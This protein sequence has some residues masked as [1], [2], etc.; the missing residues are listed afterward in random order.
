MLAR[1]SAIEC[2]Y[3]FNFGALRRE[4]NMIKSCSC[5]G[6]FISNIGTSKFMTS[7]F[8]PLHRPIRH[9]FHSKLCSLPYED[10]LCSILGSRK[11]SPLQRRSQI[12]IGRHLYLA[13]ARSRC[14]RLKPPETVTR[15]SIVDV[16]LTPASVHKMQITCSHCHHLKND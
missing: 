1:I 13:L 14:D 3:K 15:V 16:S 10:R 4:S 5:S 9:V 12:P 11:W 7:T 8:F 2:F 6:E